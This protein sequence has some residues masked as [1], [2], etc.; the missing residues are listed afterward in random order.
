MANPKFA[1]IEYMF[2]FDEKSPWDNSYDFE[3]SLGE[4]FAAHGYD[5]ELVKGLEGGTGKRM[6]YIFKQDE[7]L[8]NVNPPVNEPPSK[9]L[10]NMMGKKKT[11]VQKI[12][13]G[14]K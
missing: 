10:D 9:I 2:I 11:L 6:F 14:K 1:I 13:K 3:K 12:T 5:S 8:E 4:Y 7:L